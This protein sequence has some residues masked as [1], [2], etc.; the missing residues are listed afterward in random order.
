MH[1]IKQQNVRQE[2]E[3]V[4]QFKYVLHYKNVVL[5]CDVFDNKLVFKQEI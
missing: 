1:G 5:T 4:A 2:R 3:I